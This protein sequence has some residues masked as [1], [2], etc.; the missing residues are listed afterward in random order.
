LKSLQLNDLFIELLV[1]YAKRLHNFCL[2]SF[3]TKPNY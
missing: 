2:K 3:L 1:K